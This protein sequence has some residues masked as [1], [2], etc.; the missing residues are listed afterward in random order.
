MSMCVLG[1]QAVQK[2]QRGG[3]RLEGQGETCVGKYTPRHITF[4]QQ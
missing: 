3:V 1:I 4:E 2:R